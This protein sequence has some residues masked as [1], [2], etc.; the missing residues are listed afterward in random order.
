M[1]NGKK[2]TDGQIFGDE[3]VRVLKELL[4]KEWVTREYNPDYGI[5]LSVE[6]FEGY[7]NKDKKIYMT[8]GEHVYFQVKGTTDLQKG[9]Y[10]IEG[11]WSIDRTY[12]K[13]TSSKEVEVVKFPLD[14]DL[15]S[16]VERMGSAVPVL[17][18]VVDLNNRVGYYVCL[19]DYIEK[20]IIPNNP[21]YYTKEK[22]V[23]N[24]PIQNAIKNDNDVKAIKWYGKRAK[25]FA[26]FSKANYQKSILLEFV[27]DEELLKQCIHFATIIT[28][29]DAWS[30]SEY[31]PLLDRLKEQLDNLLKNGTININ[32]NLIN[33][34]EEKTELIKLWTEICFMGD[35]FEDLLKEKFLP[36]Y[37]EVTNREVLNNLQNLWKNKNS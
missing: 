7:K 16:T 3:G 5:D 1:G 2:R 19:N 28:R 22:L 13:F 10:K 26:L 32:E 4:P 18:V 31:V 15:I 14:T 29:Y 8:T 34:S 12:D 20:V 17:L 27:K 23:I 6:I 30:A 25:L 37:S 9:K 24:I 35:M 11:Y 21:K 33:P 36:T